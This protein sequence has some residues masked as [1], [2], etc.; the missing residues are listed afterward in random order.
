MDHAGITRSTFLL[1]ESREYDLEYEQR[2][3]LKVDGEI[4]IK[5]IFGWGW[6]GTGL[7]LHLPTNCMLVMNARELRHANTRPNRPVICGQGA[8]ICGAYVRVTYRSWHHEFVGQ[9]MSPGHDVLGIP[10]LWWDAGDGM[11]LY[12][13]AHRVLP[14]LGQ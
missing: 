11:R 9:H 14:Q 5:Y 6:C 7:A 10:L 8:R 13:R 3:W 1:F 12:I 2:V 4:E